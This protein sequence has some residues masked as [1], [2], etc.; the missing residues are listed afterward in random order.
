MV[1]KDGEA[2]VLVL[3]LVLRDK[4]LPGSILLLPDD[5]F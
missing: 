3:V 1:A 4:M 2:V 5:D